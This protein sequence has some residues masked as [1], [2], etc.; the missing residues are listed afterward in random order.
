MFA[1]TAAS[2]TS[3]SPQPRVFPPRATQMSVEH[4]DL[5]EN[6]VLFEAMPGSSDTQC[7][8]GIGHMALYP[9]TPESGHSDL[10]KFE[11]PVMETGT[12]HGGLTSS[13]LCADD[14][15]TRWVC[16]CVELPGYARGWVP[17]RSPTHRTM[18]Y[19]PLYMFYVHK[20]PYMHPQCAPHVAPRATCSF[21]STRGPRGSVS[22]QGNFLGYFESLPLW[23]PS[24]FVPA[25]PRAL[26]RRPMGTTLLPLYFGAFEGFSTIKSSLK[27]CTCNL[28]TASKRWES[29]APSTKPRELR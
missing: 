27:A 26:A 29:R 6:I 24:D 19:P 12:R 10:A 14:P 9:M 7:P 22:A 18:L 2:R 1:A 17:K 21:P 20:S 4:A 25:G 8:P 11:V 13:G 16:R 23:D 5:S 15:P 28:T 3:P